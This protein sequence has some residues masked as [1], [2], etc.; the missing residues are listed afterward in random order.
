MEDQPFS[1]PVVSQ[2]NQH[3]DTYIHAPNE[4]E[5]CEPDVKIT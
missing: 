4:I 2:E 1:G 3:T 5:V